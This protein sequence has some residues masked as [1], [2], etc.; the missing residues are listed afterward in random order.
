M[1]SYTE[2]SV[3]NPGSPSFAVWNTLHTATPE[4]RGVPVRLR[5]QQ[6]CCLRASCRVDDELDPGGIPLPPL[7]TRPSRDRQLRQACCQITRLR[8][9]TTLRVSSGQS[10]LL[11][12]TPSR[13]RW[14]KS[15]PRQPP[16]GS[17][18]LSAMNL[19]TGEKICISEL[20]VVCDIPIPM[21]GF[22]CN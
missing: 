6:R 2:S 14:V 12:S 11:S 18:L 15:S 9:T 22:P 19:R 17:M 1:G 16:Y 5:R 8:N 20:L 13:G 10:A 4:D 7:P 21:E 3:K